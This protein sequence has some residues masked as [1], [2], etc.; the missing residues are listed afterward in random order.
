MNIPQKLTILDG[1]MA[2]DGGSI[3]LMGKDQA[4]N[5]MEISLDW[6]L[7]AQANCTTTLNL[8]K[9]SL[10]KRSREEEKLLDVLKDAKIQ[11]SDAPEQR[12][13]RPTKKV[14]L[15]EDINNYLN[16]IEDGPEAALRQ[17][18]DHLISSVMSE[19]YTRAQPLNNTQE[20][21]RE[22]DGPCSLCGKPGYVQALPGAPVSDIRCEDCAQIRTFNPIAMLMNV[23]IILGMGLLIYFVIFLVKRLF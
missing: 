8:N 22:F 7:E 1:A 9:M 20:K 11:S 12:A 18:I 21:S 4:G 6:S 2:M 23:V 13:S 3:A 16:T 10:E 15:G 19:T 5:I 14:A 17:L